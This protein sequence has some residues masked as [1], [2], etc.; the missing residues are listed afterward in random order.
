METFEERWKIH[1]DDNPFLESGDK[2]KSL[3]PQQQAAYKV[4]MP[5][6]TYHWA[7]E[8]YDYKS[9]ELREE[10][11]CNEERKRRPRVTKQEPLDDH[12]VEDTLI[13]LQNDTPQASFDV[14]QSYG[15]RFKRLKVAM[16]NVVHKI[17]GLFA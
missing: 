9:E 4:E 10:S 3:L 7:E 12:L 11:P 2:D 13:P 16:K 14:H 17:R 8:W 1:D 5:Q 6:Q 15:E